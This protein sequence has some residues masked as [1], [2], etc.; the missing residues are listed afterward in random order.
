ME[1]LV[2]CIEEG[3][4][5]V[6]QEGCEDSTLVATLLPIEANKYLSLRSGSESQDT[7]VYVIDLGHH[8]NKCW[9]NTSY[10]ISY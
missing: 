5:A 2:S 3:K 10:I 1:Q 6:V 8:H 7:Q 4:R 9:Y